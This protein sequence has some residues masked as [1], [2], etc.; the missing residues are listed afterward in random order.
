MKCTVHVRTVLYE[1]KL[2]DTVGSKYENTVVILLWYERPLLSPY[3]HTW[4]DIEYIQ[5][6]VKIRIKPI[7][8]HAYVV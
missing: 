5:C 6:T 4:Y 8:V 3:V 2:F 7:I 1:Y